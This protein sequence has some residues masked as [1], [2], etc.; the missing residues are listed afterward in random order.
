MNCPFDEAQDMLREPQATS[1]KAHF[2]KLIA[3]RDIATVDSHIKK[4]VDHIPIQ[5]LI[6][7]TF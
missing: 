5:D 7:L 4:K 3:N 6:D 2:S 1:F